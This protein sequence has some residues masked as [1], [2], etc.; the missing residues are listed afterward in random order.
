[1]ATNFLE[2]ATTLKDLG[3][4]WL[5]EKKVNFMPCIQWLVHGPMTSYNETVYRQVQ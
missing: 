4:K 2:L 3:A 5:P 1:M